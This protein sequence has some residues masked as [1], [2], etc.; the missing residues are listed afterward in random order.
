MVSLLSTSPKVE[1]V[2]WRLDRVALFNV[3]TLL[4][5][6]RIYIGPN[7]VGF[8]IETLLHLLE[9]ILQFQNDLLEVLFFLNHIVE[10]ATQLLHL[11]VVR[12]SLV[13]V[14]LGFDP[15]PRKL[16]L[17]KLKLSVVNLFRGRRVRPLFLLV[18]SLLVEI[19]EAGR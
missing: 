18:Q 8:A 11:L 14:Q 7:I 2:A 9:V 1:Q 16:V 13:L 4:L 10:T 17:E 3:L 19:L 12:I 6:D 5:N 15:D